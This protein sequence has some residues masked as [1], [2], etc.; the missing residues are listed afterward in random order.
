MWGPES[1]RQKDEEIEELRSRVLD[2]AI[3]LVKQ[4]SE[5]ERVQLFRNFCGDCGIEQRKGERCHCRND[6]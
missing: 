1:M 6:E 4:L 3:E 2:M 5:S